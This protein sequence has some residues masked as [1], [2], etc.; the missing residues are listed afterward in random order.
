MEYGAQSKTAKIK[1]ILLKHPKDAYISQEHLDENREAFNYLG[2]PDY[3]TVLEEF[4]IFVEQVKKVVDDIYYLPKDDRTGLDSIYAQDSLKITKKGGIYF[5]MGKELRRREG[6]A[7]QDYLESLGIPTLGR[8]EG[9]G[10]MEG[11]DV[12]WLDEKT[13]AI[14]RS[15]RTNIEGIRQFE[16]LTKDFIDEVI[17]VPIPHANGKDEILHLTSLISMLDQDLAVIYSR[18][19]PAFFRDILLERGI[20]LLEVDDEEYD[21]LGTNVLALAPRVCLIAE[22][23]PKITKQMEDEGCTVY[24]YPGSELSMKGMG[25]PTCLT[26]AIYR[27]PLE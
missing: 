22:G 3:E 9:E 27:E 17:P 23:L 11:G 15:Y 19:M 2:S 4:D 7:S 26:H 25:G 21:R 16:E 14:G 1:S 24:T 18:Y 12:L 8:I 13:V 6:E 20:K 10:T 5:Q